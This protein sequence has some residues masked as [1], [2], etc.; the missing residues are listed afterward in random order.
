MFTYA[1][2]FYKQ[3]IEPFP[4][5]LSEQADNL[6]DLYDTKI[7]ISPTKEID[8][9]MRSPWDEDKYY[10]YLAYRETKVAGPLI[11]AWEGVEE[12][13]QYMS[14]HGLT[15]DGVKYAWRLPGT[16]KIE[17]SMSEAFGSINFVSD[18]IKRL[19]R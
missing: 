6:R 5:W 10:R 17:G 2:R 7:E 11:K 14:A 1:K 4:D 15:W 16:N 12:N 18:N 9:F 19:Y 8:E 3:F 13:R